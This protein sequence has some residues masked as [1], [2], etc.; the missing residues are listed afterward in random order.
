MTG[1]VDGQSI[2]QP[3]TDWRS[4]IDSLFPL[5]PGNGGEGRHCGRSRRGYDQGG[6]I[7]RCNVA[8]AGGVHWDV[9]PTKQTGADSE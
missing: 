3:V 4:A 7:A 2:A 8:R 5:L 1:C 6:T 9:D